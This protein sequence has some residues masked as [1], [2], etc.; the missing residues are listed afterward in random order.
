MKIKTLY[1][2]KGLP[3]AAQKSLCKEV[4]AKFRTADRVFLNDPKEEANFAMG[5]VPAHLSEHYELHER[6]EEAM[7]LIAPEEAPV[8]P[9]EDES[10]QDDEFDREAAMKQLTDAGVTVRSNA[11]V[12]TIKEKLEA[13]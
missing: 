3:T 12:A 4:G 6:H 7:A 13:L 8:K 2:L 10:Q 9:E 5:E 11:S 1:F